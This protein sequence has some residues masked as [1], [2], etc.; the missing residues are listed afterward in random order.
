MIGRILNY[1]TL[2]LLLGA[3]C[4]Y[5]FDRKSQEL[6]FQKRLDQIEL[7]RLNLE[8]SISKLKVYTTQRDSVLQHA[9]QNNNI[10][11]QHL[12]SSLKK[13]NASSK[14]IDGE[15]QKNKVSIDNLWNEN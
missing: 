15:I 5:Y 3:G 4:W 1:V 9:I 11:I 8:D 6:D 12:N 2:A 14:Q 10:I 7:T 13:I